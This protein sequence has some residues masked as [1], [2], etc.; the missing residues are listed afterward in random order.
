M[1][2][3]EAEI[4][5]SGTSILSFITFLL[6]SDAFFMIILEECS[7]QFLFLYILIKS[8]NICTL[9]TISGRIMYNR[10][11]RIV[12]MCHFIHNYDEYRLIREQ[13]IRRV[14]SNNHKTRA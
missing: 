8:I 11:E 5:I 7:E 10:L 9:T 3:N 4:I 13:E 2:I 1:D 12:L 14:G 6:P